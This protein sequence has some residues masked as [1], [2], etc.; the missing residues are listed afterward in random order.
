LNNS[1]SPTSLR[2]D[3]DRL[4]DRINELGKIGA[5]PGGGVSR[6]A[7]TDADKEARDQ[8]GTWMRELGLRFR[9]DGIGNVVGIRSGSEEVRP[10]MVGSHIDTVKTG[11]LYD[12]S[13]GVLAGLEVIKVLNDAGV[14]TRRPIAVA[15]FTNEEG[16]RFAPF[17]LG[18]L[19]FRG[20]LPLE[21]AYNIVGYDGKRVGDELERIGYRGDALVGAH[22]PHAY[23]ELHIEQ[24]PVLEAN[25]ATIGAVTG[26]QGISWTEYSIEGEASHA[27]TTPMPFRSDAGY[28]ACAIGLFVRHLT[29]DHAGNPLGTV[30]SISLHP[31]LVNV[32]AERA[33]LTVDLRNTDEAALQEAETE[34]SEFVSRLAEK[35]GLQI[36]GRKMARFEPVEFAP[37]IVNGVERTAQALGLSV[38]RL[39]SGAGHDAQ[40]MAPLCR[41]GMI[42][43]PSTGGL[44]H[45]PKEHTEPKD[46]EAGANV[47]L[48]MVLDLAS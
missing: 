48:Q 14:T 5:L 21:E 10:V 6:L 19:V 18:S 42:F 11:G 13:L 20:G 43:V 2:I 28:A 32:V 33:K 39:P 41:T 35:E 38:K 17:A 29:L 31:N 40:M 24:G 3:I 12:G 9:I 22:K 47:L 27:G 36:Q 1:A 26:V 16:A 34:L 4:M 8:V 44:S 25:K 30:G 45:N 46:I 15:F 37:K 7:L 23:V